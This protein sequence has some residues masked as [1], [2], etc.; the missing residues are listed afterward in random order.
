MNYK[1][2]ADRTRY[3]KENPKGVSEMCQG[4]QEEKKKA[5]MRMLSDGMLT[6]EKIAKYA[7]L[8]IDEVKKLKK[9]Q[10]V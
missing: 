1:L 6:I 7:E 8:S 5:V 3:L 4:M 9:E 10:T 2:M